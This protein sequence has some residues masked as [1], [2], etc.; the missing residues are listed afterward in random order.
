M[1]YEVHVTVEKA[2]DIDKF[3][4][5]C[6]WMKVKPIII[7]T[8]NGQL[9]ENQVMT[10]SKH[11]GDDYM[12]TLNKITTWL[13]GLGYKVIREKVEKKPIPTKDIDFK[14]YECHFRLKMDR[15]FDKDIIK[16]LCVDNGFHLSRNLFKHDKYFIYQMCTFRS[17]HISYHQFL[18]Q[19]TKFS[20]RLQEN[21][22]KYDKIET[23]ECIYDT[24]ENIDYK[25]LTVPLDSPMPQL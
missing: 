6:E 14:Y 19:I 13:I 5:D 23:E 18:Y 11:V 7:E 22:M 12:I 9:I 4:R 15:S 3:K 1:E 8:Q 20:L 24:N 17:N 25:W 16:K 10:S 21:G 2:Y